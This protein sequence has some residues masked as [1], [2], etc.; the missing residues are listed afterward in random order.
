MAERAEA[1]QET[2]QVLRLFPSFVWK[3]RLP[4]EV[5]A[6]VSPRAIDQIQALRRSLPALRTGQSWQSGHGLHEMEGFG[7]LI[8]RIRAAATDVLA[9]LEITH[10][11]FE[12]PGCW[13]NVYARGAAHRMHSHPNNYLS[14]VYYV[15]VCAGANTINFHDP[16]MQTAILRPPVRQLTAENTDQVVVRVEEGTLLVFP[17]WLQHSVDANRSTRERISISFNFMFSSYTESMSRP[18]WS[19]A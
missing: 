14:G 6:A 12:I 3:A 4:A 7:G 13:A 1:R 5:R 8:A 19:G 9:F 17:A 11:G 18:L 10:E 16:R 2:A 15:Q